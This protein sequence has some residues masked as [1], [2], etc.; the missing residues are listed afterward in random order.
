MKLM[1]FFVY[2]FVCVY[3]CARAQASAY[4]YNGGSFEFQNDVAWLDR[5]IAFDVNARNE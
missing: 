4:V 3:V 2:L 1:D 5:T